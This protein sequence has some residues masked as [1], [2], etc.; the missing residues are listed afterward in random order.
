[1]REFLL[2]IERDLVVRIIE[3]D[4]LKIHRYSTLLLNFTFVLIRS[5]NNRFT[6]K[7]SALKVGRKVACKKHGAIALE[8]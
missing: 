1:M 6:S 8:E 4:S 3:F 5:T 2:G 7:L